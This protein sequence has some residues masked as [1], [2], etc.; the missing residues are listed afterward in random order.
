MTESEA[1]DSNSTQ[2]KSDKRIVQVKLAS[3]AAS[4]KNNSDD[5]D[6]SN[7]S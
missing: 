1:E 5:S 2:S 3:E 6:N 4:K 7:D